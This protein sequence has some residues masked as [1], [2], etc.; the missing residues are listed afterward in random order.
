MPKPHLFRPILTHPDS[1]HRLVNK[2]RGVVLA[3]R[4]EPAFDSN[5]RRRGLLGRSELPRG[6]VLAIAPSN[7]VH[8]F[9]MQFPIDVVFIRRDGQVVKV[10]RNL[11]ARRITFA[12]G[13]F[14]VLEFGAGCQ[15]VALTQKGDQL[16]VEPGP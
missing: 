9:K 3:T 2:T 16:A 14:A 4:I 11:G 8:T 10:V 13:A 1:P 12:W 5:S 7:A 15:E 6:T